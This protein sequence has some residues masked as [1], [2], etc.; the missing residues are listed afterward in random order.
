M[1][2]HNGHGADAHD[3]HGDHGGHHHGPYEAELELIG[4]HGIVAEYVEPEDLLHA[5]EA[6][7][8]AG[9]KKMDAYSPMP[10]HGLAEA[11]GFFDDRVPWSAFF[12]GLC[13]C[14]GGW[15]IQY[16]VAVIDYPWNVGGKPLLSWPQMIPVAYELTI[17]NAAFSVAGAMIALN[18]LPR[19][20][21]SIFN[22]KNFERATSDRFFLCIESDDPQF[23][24]VETARFLRTT[25]GVTEVSE[26]AK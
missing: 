1:A 3:A 6:A 11:I 10:I 18:G 24:P 26:V 15:M 16:F 2:A 20:Y 12:G 22:A 13:G 17:F 9:Y 14:I 7:S 19:P 5:A 23:D 25:H 8:A 4:L 21:H